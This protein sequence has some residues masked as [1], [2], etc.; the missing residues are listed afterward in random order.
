VYLLFRKK[1]DDVYR[2][3]FRG[4]VRKEKKTQEKLKKNSLCCRSGEKK[5]NAYEQKN[6]A[7]FFLCLSVVKRWHHEN[8][9]SSRRLLFR[10][11]DFLFGFYE[12]RMK[13][14]KN[15]H[16]SRNRRRN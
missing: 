12:R 13:I 11:C 1:F 3:P 10:Y 16:T 8:K 6:G 9:R 7:V 2:A 4:F 5:T 14:N 15:E